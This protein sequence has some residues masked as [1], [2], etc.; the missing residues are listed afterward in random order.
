MAVKV[1]EKARIKEIAG[2]G[3][4]HRLVLSR[5]RPSGVPVGSLATGR[6]EASVLRNA[7]VTRVTRE[8]KIFKMVEHPFV[9]RLY[10]VCN[11]KHHILLVSEFASDG[12]L[13]SYIVKHGRLREAVAAR[14]F[15]QLLEGVDY[16]H[17]CGVVHRDLKVRHVGHV[18]AAIAALAGDAS[19]AGWGDAPSP[20]AHPHP[21][22]LRTL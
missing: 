18:P 17:D 13:F 10:E 12:E 19:V 6:P 16:L 14:L 2:E 21:P 8:I 20:R 15:A 5:E 4:Q 1:L 7:D 22:L 3:W 11:T 9:C